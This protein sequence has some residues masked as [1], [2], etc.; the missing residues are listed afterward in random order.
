MRKCKL[1]YNFSASKYFIE[2]RLQNRL[3]DD[4]AK[5]YNLARAY[6]S[7]PSLS[8]F[9]FFSWKFIRYFLFLTHFTFIL[10]ETRPNL[11]QLLNSVKG[12]N[13]L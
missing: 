10:T 8:N 11:P 5:L 12:Y 1:Y 6:L 3:D 13:H 7:P 4:L 2:N 9:F